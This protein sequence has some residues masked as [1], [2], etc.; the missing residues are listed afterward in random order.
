M[1]RILIFAVIVIIAPPVIGQY[2]QLQPKDTL[3]PEYPYKL[4]FLGSAAYEKG[5]N[6]PK[7]LGLML[8]YFWATQ[9][10]VIPK[11]ELGFSD[12][13]LP[14]VPLTE[15]TD[16]LEFEEIKAVA[17]TINVRPDIWIF[18]FL[19]VYGIFGKS[20]ATTD[21]KLSSPVEL[22]AHAE[23]E[24]ISYGVGTTG[25]FGVGKYFVVLDGNW[26]WT[27]MSNFKQPVRSAVFSQ[28]IGRS[29][30]V[31]AN[32][33]SNFAVWV[34]GMRVKMGNVTQGTITLNEV[35]PPE[36]WQRRDEIVASYWDWYDTLD[37]LDQVLADQIFTPIVD[38]IEQAD[39][40]GSVEYSLLKEP[41]RKWNL[42][43]GGQ[44]QLNKSWQIRAEGG[45][46]GN[47][48]SFLLSVNY[49]FGL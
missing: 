29:F 18:P 36:T 47:R 2:S 41:K 33:E 49:R 5:F 21:V 48:K 17:Q 32:P 40:S 34:G 6:L 39:G 8:N 13:I 30:Q 9:D 38:K 43:I 45:I 42:I 3:K 14:E 28:R 31:G 19:N 26:V 12:G 35:L 20:Y 22:A 46:I 1:R 24:G 23:L 44:Y 15:I 10:I 11:I 25:A 27:S 16:L 4:P 37:R 7:P